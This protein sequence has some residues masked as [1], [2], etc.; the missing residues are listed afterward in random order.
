MLE[1]K[2]SHLITK[3]LKK[4]SPMTD[5][6]KLEKRVKNLEEKVA[7]LQEN[8]EALGDANNLLAGKNMALLECVVFSIM[9]P[10]QVKTSTTLSATDIYDAIN[11]A[12]DSQDI[13]DSY[14]K[15]ARLGTDAFFERVLD[16]KRYRK[17]Q[18]P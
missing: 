7:N 2:L 4:G 17:D 1:S 10:N 6:N 15:G 11:A 3:K 16:N 18:K 8:L 13:P 5:A 12:L 14:K 9:N